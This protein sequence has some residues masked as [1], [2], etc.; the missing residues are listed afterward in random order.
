M[1]ASC[2]LDSICE[3]AGPCLEAALRVSDCRRRDRRRQ[4]PGSAPSNLIQLYL[5]VQKTKP[6][7]AS[8][9]LYYA[10]ELPALLPMWKKPD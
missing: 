1:P 10:W 2:R 8:I 6:A 9:A 7:A 3:C 5:A 4:M